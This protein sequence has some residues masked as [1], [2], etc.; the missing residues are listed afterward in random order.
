MPTPTLFSVAVTGHRPDKL[1]GYRPNPTLQHIDTLLTTT[2]N[3]LQTLIPSL[4]AIS[5]MAL[6]VDQL[7][8]RIC[9]RL[10]IPFSAYIPFHGQERRWPAA[11]Q[12]DYQ[13]LLQLASAIH[14]TVQPSPQPLSY[15]DI[16][17][18]LLQRNADMVAV[19]HAAI[20]V[21][22]GTPGGTAH[23]VGLIRATQMP[24]L[25]LDPARP[26]DD[27]AISHFLAHCQTRFGSLDREETARSAPRTALPG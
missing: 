16:R 25:I 18:A 12:H 15:D 10:R 26:L 8:A 1:G 14:Y 3:R 11:S 4:H 7:Y 9:T 27:R 5:G 2:L 22:N 19:A 24:L 17:R 23:A 13:A 21:W 6:G 20:A